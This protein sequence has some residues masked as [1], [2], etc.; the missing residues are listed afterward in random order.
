LYF[1]VASETGI[2]GLATFGALV[3][4]AF[5]AVH[6]SRALAVRNALI[7]YLIASVFLHAAFP[8]I[9]WLLLALAWATPQCVPP[10]N[11]FNIRRGVSERIP[12]EA[13]R[14]GS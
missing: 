14:T 1:E 3:V 5:A 8:Q 9:L 2:L 6:R 13:L 10:S 12:N 11:T 4:G 7:G